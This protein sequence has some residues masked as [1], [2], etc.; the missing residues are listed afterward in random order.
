M[1]GLKLKNEIL[2]LTGLKYILDKGDK[3]MASNSG[4]TNLAIR[5]TGGTDY[6]D[7]RPLD[8]VTSLTVV[9]SFYYSGVFS[10]EN[11]SA[12]SFHWK[13]ADAGAGQNFQYDLQ[14][15]DNGSDWITYQG[16]TSKV[17]AGATETLYDSTSTKNGVSARYA[18]FFVYQL[19]G[20][21]AIAPKILFNLKVNE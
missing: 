8:S 2:N 20:A 19:A 15:S 1:N 16:S 7:T 6:A 3:K 14:V 21:S 5:T 10:L 18:R 4:I 11:C 17:G 12:F 9:D 13:C